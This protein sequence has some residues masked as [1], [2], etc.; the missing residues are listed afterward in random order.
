MDDRVGPFFCVTPEVRGDQDDLVV[1]VNPISFKVEE[2]VDLEE[3]G[4]KLLAFA[5]VQVRLVTLG[6]GSSGVGSVGSVYS[7]VA[8][9]EGV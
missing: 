5:M 7:N 9:R 6:G 2:T 3:P 8:Y 4:G 1:V